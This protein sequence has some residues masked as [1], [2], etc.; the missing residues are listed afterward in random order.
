MRREA[1]S[2]EGPGDSGSKLPPSALMRASLKVKPSPSERPFLFFFAFC[3]IPRGGVVVL[4]RSE[5]Y[6]TDNKPDRKLNQQADSGIERGDGGGQKLD[7]AALLL[8]QPVSSPVNLPRGAAC[9]CAGP[10]VGT[11]HTKL[12]LCEC[13]T[14]VDRHVHTQIVSGLCC[15]PL[16]PPLAP[17]DFILFSQEGSPHWLSPIGSR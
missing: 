15:E 4:E 12:S 13:Q 11:R 7:L 2:A 9:L 3:E 16:L 17:T 5:V 6:K 1:S 10:P 8:L 14:C